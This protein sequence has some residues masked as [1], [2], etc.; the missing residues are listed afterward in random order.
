MEYGHS[1]EITQEAVRPLAILA[2]KGCE[3]MGNR[4]NDFL[5]RWTT[6]PENERLFTF[7]GY[8]NDSFLINA[9]CPRFG[10]GEAKGFIAQ[11][12]R[13]YDLYI[14]CDVTNYRVT[15]PIYGNE[16]HMSPDDHFSDL[17]RLIAAA[18]AKPHRITV[19]MP[20]LYEGRQHRR[21]GRESLDCAIAL[22][23]LYAM[24]VNNILTFDAHDPRVVNAVPINNFDNIMPT[25][26]MLK[27]LLKSFPDVEIDKEHT[28]II[29]P[30]EGA[31][32]RA[33]FYA[34]MLGLD[35]GLFYKRRDYTRIEKG[36]NPIIAHEYLGSSVEGMDVFIADDIISTG[37]SMLDL[38]TE[39]KRRKARRVF[40][41]GT[42]PL[43]TNGLEPF[44]KLYEDGMFDM[45]FSTNL[46][47]L[48]QRL[49]DRPWFCEVDMSK[50]IALLVATLNHDSS[51]SG[52]LSPAERINSL[53]KRHNDA[54]NG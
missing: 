24:G 34:S 50:Y 48:S 40:L 46:I 10:T 18:G 52:L 45:L 11:S 32:D 41:A 23:E 14:L 29:A 33:I 54:K 19:I 20:Y 3:E 38:A 16:N 17:K 42:F 44:D 9:A 28:M 26:Q 22:Q 43:F 5:M 49:R 6:D 15:Y 36:R 8:H 30:D 53:L 27:A 2:M 51:I 25:Y 7:P 47:H 39:L 37:E 1:P 35:M 13:G 31:A 12:V 21:N 4:V